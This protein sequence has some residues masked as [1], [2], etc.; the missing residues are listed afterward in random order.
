[1]AGRPLTQQVIAQLVGAGIAPVAAD[2]TLEF[3]MET[4]KYGLGP[5]ETYQRMLDRTTDPVRREVLQSL[6]EEAS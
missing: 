6:I 2:M 3:V 5:T 4:I 1:M